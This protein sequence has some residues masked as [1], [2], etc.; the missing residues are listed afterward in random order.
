[1]NRIM[2]VELKIKDIAGVLYQAE[3]NCC[4]ADFSYAAMPL[5]FC[6]KMRGGTIEKF[7]NKGIG[8]IGVS[9]F[10]ATIIIQ[11]ERNI[12]KHNKDV[13]R[14]L[15]NFKIRHSKLSRKKEVK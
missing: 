4:V 5:Q 15:W 3:T 13:C 8:L 2:A 14:R 11:A 10:T 7:K 1:M 9:Q 12:I 6:Q